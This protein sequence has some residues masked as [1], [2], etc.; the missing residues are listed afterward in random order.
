MTAQGDMLS[1]AFLRVLHISWQAALIVLLI[2]AIQWFLGKRLH[3]MIRHALWG[4][5]LAV[6]VTA[7]VRDV[8]QYLYLRTTA[9]GAT[10]QMA[11]EYLRAR[12]L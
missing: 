2:A 4:L 12:S 7:V 6:P 10:P 9:R 11:L 5:L 8:F 1:A 3:P